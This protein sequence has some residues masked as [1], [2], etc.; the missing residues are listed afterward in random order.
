M[1]QSALIT[2]PA[3]EYMTTML[4]FVAAKFEVPYYG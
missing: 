4:Y 2:G 1:P 3:L